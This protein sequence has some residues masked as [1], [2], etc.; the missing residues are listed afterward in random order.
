MVEA[1]EVAVVLLPKLIVALM[2]SGVMEAVV[3]VI[4]EVLGVIQVL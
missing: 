1:V 2:R 3:L 4:L